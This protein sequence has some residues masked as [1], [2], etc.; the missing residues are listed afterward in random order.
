M[1]NKSLSL[2]G[3]FPPVPTPFKD[4]GDVAYD[5]LLANL[6][7]LNQQPLSGY[8]MGGSNGEFTSLTNEE[9]VQAVRLAREAAPRE[10][11]IIAGSGMES[12]RATIALTEQMAQAGADVAIVVTPGYFRGRMTAAALEAHYREVAEAAA[13][14]VLLY[15][16]PANTGVDLP[17][18]AVATLATHPN[19]IGLKDSG[20]DITKIGQMVNDTPSDFQILAGS[21]GFLLPALAVGA[22]GGVVALANIAATPLHALMTKFR[23]GDLAGA[24]ALHLPLIEANTAVTARFG[25][26]GLKAA[27]DMLG[28]YG[29]AP[30][31]PLLPLG[32]EDRATLRGILQKAKLL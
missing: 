18:A 25:V 17:A 4:N 15:S 7:K 26:A 20:G 21:A 14:P 31:M 12:T 22:V 8:V 19:I 3:L 32:D 23:Q 29:G 13:I 1:P 28:Y 6:E 24:R 27:M 10:R 5:H 2:S 9:K 16:V 11:L 30:R